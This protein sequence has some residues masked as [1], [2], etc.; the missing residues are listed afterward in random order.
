[1]VIGGIVAAIRPAADV[2]S[3]LRY[4]VVAIN[5]LG[6]RAL[7]R[8]WRPALKRMPAPAAVTPTA[9]VRHQSWGGYVALIQS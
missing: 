9:E 7:R 2:P 5:A 1:M 4:S 3:R 6:D 8:S